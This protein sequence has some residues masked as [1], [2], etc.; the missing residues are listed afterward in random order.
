MRHPLGSMLLSIVLVVIATLTFTGEKAYAC[1]CA[2]STVEERLERSSVVFLG[3]VIEKDDS[4]GAR[5][6]V[7]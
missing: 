2:N 3:T 1:S 5:F 4:G 7:E 6:N